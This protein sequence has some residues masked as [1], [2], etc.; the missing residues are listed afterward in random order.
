MRKWGHSRKKTEPIEIRRASREFVR[1]W[2]HRLFKTR[3]KFEAL[4]YT[5]VTMDEAHFHDSVMS[6]RFWSQIGVR[7][8]MLWTGNHKR[9]SMMCSMTSDNRTFF[10]HCTTANTQTFL[11]HIEQVYQK[12]GKMVLVL[13]RASY[14]KSKKAMAYFKTR[15]IILVWY[16]TGHPYLNPVEEVWKSAQGGSRQFCTLCRL[17]DTPECSLSVYRS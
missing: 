9:F 17:E 3:A 5:M 6:S 4:G 14:H 1:V 16:P 7:I 12:V 13:D 2:R 15:D 8:F 11:E 10:N